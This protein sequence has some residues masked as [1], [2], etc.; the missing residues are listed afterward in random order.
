MQNNLNSSNYLANVFVLEQF[1]AQSLQMKNSEFWGGINY[2]RAE[3]SD[4]Y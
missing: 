4:N 1:A 2:V 3:T